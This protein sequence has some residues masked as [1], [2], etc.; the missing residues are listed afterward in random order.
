VAGVSTLSALRASCPISSGSRQN[1]IR[2][3]DRSLGC[4]R[5]ARER[6]LHQYD[7]HPRRPGRFLRGASRYLKSGAVFAFYGPFR[8]G[9][10]HTSQSNEDFDR[11]CALKIPA[12]VSAISLM[13]LTQQRRKVRLEEVCQMPANNLTV[14][15]RSRS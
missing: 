4:V 1:V 9:D 2:N 7:S 10:R 8:R 3:L 5:R 15:F 12:G 6:H 13:S 14:I 11:V